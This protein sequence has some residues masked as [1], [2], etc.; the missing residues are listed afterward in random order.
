MTPAAEQEPA[1]SSDQNAK[2]RRPTR[3][4]FV[5]YAVFFFLWCIGLII[6]V[7]DEAPMLFGM[8]FWFL[9]SCVFS[10]V[11]ICFILIRV[12]RRHF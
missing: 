7:M 10:Y 1:D 11:L 4:I 9:F 5:L 2:K 6:G 8:P 3:A 12:V